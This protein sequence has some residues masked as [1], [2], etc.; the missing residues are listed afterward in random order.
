MDLRLKLNDGQQTISC[1]ELLIKLLSWR[2]NPQIT[3]NVALIISSLSQQERVA[4]KFEGTVFLTERGKDFY[5]F[6]SPEGIPALVELM[7]QAGS[8][9]AAGDF[10]DNVFDL[11]Y[12]SDS[13]LFLSVRC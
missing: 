5:L 2:Q 8:S 12:F 9:P 13:C 6:I 3:G 11:E 1:P 7:K 4:D 10:L